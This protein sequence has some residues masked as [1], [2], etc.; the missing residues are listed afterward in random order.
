[1]ISVIEVAVLP[2]CLPVSLGPAAATS[3]HLKLSLPPRVPLR[4][5]NI[6]K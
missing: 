6:L 2:L 4:E 1:M 5:C 3:K